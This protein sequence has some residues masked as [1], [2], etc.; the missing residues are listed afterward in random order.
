MCVSGHFWD[1]DVQIQPFLPFACLWVVSKWME[2]GPVKTVGKIMSICFGAIFREFVVTTCNNVKQWWG[3]CHAKRLASVPRV[4]CQCRGMTRSVLLIDTETCQFFLFANH[5]PLSRFVWCPMQLMSP[6]QQN[7]CRL[8]SSM[9]AGKSA[10]CS[11]CL[12]GKIIG[13]NEG[14]SS[15]V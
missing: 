1:L 10:N 6:P 14:F 8:V 7:N 4:T 9:L 13:L 5:P 15:H 2:Q 3:I 11:W 12:D